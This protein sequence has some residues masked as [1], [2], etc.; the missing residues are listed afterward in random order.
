MFKCKYIN[1]VFCTNC[2]KENIKC[3][4]K[5]QKEKEINEFNDKLR[6]DYN[7]RTKFI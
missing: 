4:T 2:F 5:L 3:E 1:T 6:E 7:E